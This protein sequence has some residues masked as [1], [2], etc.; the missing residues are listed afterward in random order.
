MSDHALRRF[1]DRGGNP[2][3]S[4]GQTRARVADASRPGITFLD[5]AGVDEPH[6]TM[7]DRLARELLGHESLD[8][9]AIELIFQA[10]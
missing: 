6:R 5:V 4:F 9:P 10:G 3:Q 8:A 1:S 7:L 2:M